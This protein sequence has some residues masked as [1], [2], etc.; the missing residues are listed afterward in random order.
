MEKVT[1]GKAA[2]RSRTRICNYALFVAG[3]LSG[4]VAFFLVE[5]GLST[6]FFAVG[7]LCFAVGRYLTYMENAGPD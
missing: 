1:D 7:G 6:F 3:V 2:I 5:G 4:L